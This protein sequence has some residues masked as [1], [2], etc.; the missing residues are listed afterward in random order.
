MSNYNLRN[1]DHI[2]IPI[3]KKTGYVNSFMPNGIHEWN[4]LDRNIRTR[5]SIDAFKY[6]LKKARSKKKNKL[7]QRFNGRKAINHTRIR[8]GLSGLKAQRYEY[9]HVDNKTCDYC[10]ARKE[11]EMH[12]FLQCHPFSAQRAVLMDGITRLYHTKNIELDLTRTLV[13]KDLVHCL[14]RGDQRLNERENIEL[15]EMVQQF[16]HS[17]NRF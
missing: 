13:K 2:A 6:H 16:I 5:P 12:F 7:F 3:G 8:L 1:N 15:F 4:K 11:D 17:S 10:G 14:L 9:N